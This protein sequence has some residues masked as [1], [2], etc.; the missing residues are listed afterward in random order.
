MI[1]SIFSGVADIGNIWKPNPQ[2]RIASHTECI[3]GRCE[4][5]VVEL[6]QVVGKLH[7]SV[8]IGKVMSRTT[9]LEIH[10]PSWESPMAHCMGKGT[11]PSKHFSH[12]QR[13][14]P[15]YIT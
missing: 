15:G 6:P 12:F 8:C 1:V 10:G 9:N 4:V 3:T 11:A 7:G 13:D 2:F 5:D 14:I